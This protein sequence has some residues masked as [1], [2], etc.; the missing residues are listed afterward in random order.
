MGKTITVNFDLESTNVRTHNMGF[1]HSGGSFG[2]VL[3][4]GGVAGNYTVSISNTTGATID[5]NGIGMMVEPTDAT[6]Y[7]LKMTINSIKIS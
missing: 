6:G 4:K 5:I 7:T 2:A 1:Y 3:Q